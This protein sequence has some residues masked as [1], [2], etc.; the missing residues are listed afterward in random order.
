MKE[1][2]ERRITEL[3]EKI[4]YKLRHLK[5]DCKYIQGHL[6]KGELGF[7]CIDVSY[8]ETDL[9]EIRDALHLMIELKRLLKDEEHEGKD[10]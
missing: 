4:L 10:N 2:I 7:A 8:A 1:K 3:W 9:G 6:Q 5:E